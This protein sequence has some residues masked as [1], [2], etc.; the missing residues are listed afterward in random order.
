MIG[1]PGNWTHEEIRNVVITAMEIRKEKCIH[2]D[3]EHADAAN[4]KMIVNYCKEL[5]YNAESR[6]F[7]EDVKIWR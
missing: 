2:L 4:I 7:A 6:D 1:A 5:G 3:V